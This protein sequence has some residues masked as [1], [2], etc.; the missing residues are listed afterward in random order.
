MSRTTSTVL[1]AA[2]HVLFFFFF[3]FAVHPFD[4]RTKPIVETISHL[5]AAGQQSAPEARPSIPSPW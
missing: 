3:V 5:A 1:V 2:L 4:M